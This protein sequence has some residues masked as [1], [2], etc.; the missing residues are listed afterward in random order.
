V[1]Q[2]KA[3]GIKVTFDGE[4]CTVSGPTALPVGEYLFTVNDL[5]GAGPPDLKLGRF[6]GGN[7]YQDFLDAQGEPG[8]YIPKPDYLDQEITEVDVDF[9]LTTGQKSITYAL[10]EGEYAIYIFIADGAKW[11]QWICAPLK[12]VEA[13]S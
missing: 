3:E 13:S 1:A 10:E 12:V 8:T 7:T 4:V 6:T 11:G 9:D 2:A 5:E